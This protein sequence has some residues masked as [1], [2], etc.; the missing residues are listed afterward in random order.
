MK[1]IKKEERRMETKAGK[2]GKK[3]E[4]KGEE[5]CKGGRTNGASRKQERK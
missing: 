1:K 2:R 3:W 5:E 4:M